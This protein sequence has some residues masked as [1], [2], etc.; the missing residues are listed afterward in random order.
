MINKKNDKDIA[1][2]TGSIIPNLEKKYKV[3]ASR[4]PSPAIVTGI[5]EINEII[6]TTTKK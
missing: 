3:A 5:R 2:A 4:V 1:K 6:G